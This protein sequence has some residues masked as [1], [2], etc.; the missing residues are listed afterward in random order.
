VF[1]TDGITERRAPDDSLFEASRLVSSL[2]G[3]SHLDIRS[4]VDALVREVDDFGAGT[5]PDD[6]E[7]VLAI[8]IQ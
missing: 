2:A 1:Y 4:M 3:T 6:D 5:E 7:T 8:A